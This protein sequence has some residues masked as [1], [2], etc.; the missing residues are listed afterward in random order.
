MK[1]WQL[2]LGVLLMLVSPKCD[3]CVDNVTRIEMRGL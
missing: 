3:K 2:K 1:N